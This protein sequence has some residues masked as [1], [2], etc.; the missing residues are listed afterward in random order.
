MRIRKTW[1]TLCRENFEDGDECI[2]CKQCKK[3]FHRECLQAEGL[4]DIEQL[5]DIKNYICYQCM[6]EDDD[7]PENEDRCKICRE[8]SSNLILLL[9]DG[10]PNSYHV[11]CLGLQAEPESEK[12]YCP[13]CKPEEHKNL[14]VRRMRKGFAIDNMNGDHV[15]SSSCYV[16]QRPGKLLGCDFCPNSFHPTC[17]PDLDFDNISDQWECPCCKNEDPLLNQGHKRWT[18]NEIQEI[19]KKRQKELNFW[20]SKIIKYRNRFLLAHRKDL[21][22]FVNP[23]VFANLTKTFKNDFYAAKCNTNKKGGKGDSGKGTKI[24]S[25]SSN[26]SNSGKKSL[27]L[28][29]KEFDE[30]IS[31]LEEEANK[32]ASKFIES[33]FLS[34]YQP[35]GK[36]IERRPLVDNVQLKPHQEDGV[37]WLLKSF[38]TGGA[39]LAD[40]MGLGKTI[41]TLCFLSYLKCN[42]IDGP[43]LIVVPLSTVGN[44]LR[45]IHRFTP[46][47]TCIKICGSKNERTH[48][49]EDRLAEKGL[50]DLYVTT[51]E[52]V[53]NEEEF[54]VETIPKW[55]CI[56]L[57]EAHRIKN[58]GGAIRHSMDR[59]VGNMRLL[60]TGTPLQNNSAELFTLI[61]FMFPDIFKNSEIIEQAF[62]NTPMGG[63]NQNNS[64]S[65]TNN[66]NGN[67]SGNSNNYKLNI[68]N[69]DLKSSIKEEDLKA[70]R[71]LLDKIMLRR[72]KEQAITLPRKIFHDV[73]LPLGSLS[74]HW[75]KRLLDIRSMV[76]E[77]VSVKKLL[78]LV[79][80]M[81]IICGHPKGI[82]SRPSQ[83]E[84]LFAFFEEESE[85]IKEEVKKD[86]IKLKNISGEEH[87]ESS[88]KLI[89]ID[90]LLCQL[91]YE[92]CKYVKNY[93]ANFDKHKKEVAIYH[94]HKMQEQNQSQ[95]KKREHSGKFKKNEAL[96]NSPLFMEIYNKGKL[97]LKPTSND[98]DKLKSFMHTVSIDNECPYKKKRCIYDKIKEMIKNKNNAKF[99]QNNLYSVKNP[100]KDFSEFHYKENNEN[101]N[102]TFDDEDEE[103]EEEEEE[104]TED[105]EYNYG[106]KN[107]GTKK[108][109][110]KNLK[111]VFPDEDSNDGSN[112]NGTDA[113]KEEK[114]ENEEQDEKEEK[115][116]KEE[117]N[118]Q[119]ES[120]E[121][122]SN[123]GINSKNIVTL[124]KNCKII[125]IKEFFKSEKESTN[126]EGKTNENSTQIS[127]KE[128]LEKIDADYIK[129]E[130]EG[131]TI[132]TMHLNK[133]DTEEKMMQ[134]SETKDEN[135]SKLEKNEETEENNNIVNVKKEVTIQL[136]FTRSNSNNEEGENSPK[137]EPKMHKVLIFTQFQLVLDE[138]EE[139]CKY[140]CWKYMRLDGSTN[141]L[142]RELDIREFNLSDS[143]YFI[144]LI[145]TRAGGLGINLTAAN[146]VIMYDEDWN[147]FIDLQAIDRAHRIGQKREVNVWKLMTE[148]TVEERMAFRREQKLKLDKLVVQT[149]ED[150]DMLDNFEEKLSSDEI[151]KLM[152]HGKA[153]I[154]N[155]DVEETLDLPL[156]FFIERGRRKLPIIN[157]IDLEKE[158]KNT[159]EQE[160][161][162]IKEDRDQLNSNDED[163]IY[164]Q[165][166]NYISDDEGR[167][168][169][170][171]ENGIDIDEV[172]LD[173]A[174]ELLDQGPNNNGSG[175]FYEDGNNDNNTDAVKRD[176]EPHGSNNSGIGLTSQYSSNNNGGDS[177]LWRSV[178]ERKKPQNMY[179]P[180]YWGRKQEVKQIKHEYRCFICNNT[181]NYKT[182]VKD[183]N[184]ND[185]EIDYGDMINC[186]RC[187]K[188]Y[189]KLCEGIKD[190]VVKKTWT[191]SWH[192][193]CLCF[194]KS[195]Q[196]GNLLIHCATCPT[197]F[198]YS[199]FPPD[200]IRYYVGEEYYHN[201]RQR[202]VNFN[203][204]NW[205]CFLCSK[206][207]AVEEQKKRRKMTKEERENEKQLQ[208][209]LRSQ[210][211]DSKQEEIETKKRKRAQQLERDKFIIENRKRIDALDKKY[212]M[213]L[214]SAYENLFPPKFI[215]E[216]INRI[217]QAKLL[218][219]KSGTG[220]DEENN[221]SKELSKNQNSKDSDNNTPK[222]STNKKKSTTFL[223]TKLPNKMLVLCENCK[224]PCHANY[225]YPGNCC[226]PLEL[227]K[228]YFY[229]NSSFNPSTNNKDNKNGNT[230]DGNTGCAD[231]SGFGQYPCSS[232]SSMDKKNSAKKNMTKDGDNS[233]MNQ[234]NNQVKEEEE[235]DGTE[236]KINYN[237]QNN[238]KE[239]NTTGQSN[240]NN[241]ENPTNSSR[242]NF[243]ENNNEDKNENEQ[244]DSPN[245]NNQDNNGKAKTRRFL[246]AVCSKCGT[247]QLGKLAH[248][249]KHCDKLTEEEKKEYEDKREKLKHLIELLNTKSIPDEYTE[250]EYKNMS[251]F[252]FKGLY[253]TF[254]DKADN[255]LEDCIREMK[256]D[257]LISTKKKT[258]KKEKENKK[259]NNNNNNNNG[260]NGGMGNSSG[261]S[262]GKGKGG[263][264]KD[265]MKKGGSN[266]NSS[267]KSNLAHLLYKNALINSLNKEGK[268]FIEI[269]SD[270]MTDEMKELLSRELSS[271]KGK[272]KKVINKN[273]LKTKKAKGSG[274][275]DEGNN[276]TI[277]DGIMN[278]HN[279]N[280]KFNELK[281]ISSNNNLNMYHDKLNKDKSNE[282]FTLDSFNDEFLHKAKEFLRITK[283]KIINNGFS[284]S[285]NIANVL[286]VGDKNNNMDI[287][288]SI[289]QNYIKKMKNSLKNNQP[290]PKI[291]TEQNF[292]KHHRMSSYD[293]NRS[294]S[295]SRID[296]YKNNL[297]RNNKYNI[298]PSHSNYRI[299]RGGSGDR[300]KIG[301]LV[302]EHNNNNN[303]IFTP[304]SAVPNKN[305]HYP[306]INDFNVDIFNIDKNVKHKDDSGEYDIKK[307][308][309]LSENT[310]TNKV[311]EYILYR[312]KKSN[313]NS[314][315]HHGYDE[316]NNSNF[317]AIGRMGSGHKRDDVGM[318]NKNGKINMDNQMNLKRP[319]NSANDRMKQLNL[320][321]V[322]SF[323]INA[324]RN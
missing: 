36:K 98:E 215:K 32:N 199:C 237:S 289:I 85:E 153:A 251:I 271:M 91:H 214:R 312:K 167:D 249:R 70:I 143:I 128:N 171:D 256:W 196:C 111:Q 234:N 80:K 183:R 233:N 306:D 229:A 63:N 265:G 51:Y 79:I 210:L 170:Y 59:V 75:Y 7:I 8:K 30:Y 191:C 61:N 89:F 109:K 18:K 277:E 129:K 276:N 62:M 24:T 37:E 240:Y 76:E 187:P 308:T 95:K 231:G 204:Q 175:S 176:K 1:C 127:N 285:P 202:G 11:S 135:N 238:E 200:Y 118:E 82:V 101:E 136:P 65:N 56:V 155:M 48:A 319:S 188:T 227:D 16:C 113:E 243:D 205:V 310:G 119:D 12:W 273:T 193:C 275:C 194:R 74:A 27:N 86:A 292:N 72:L 269:I 253:S 177:T 162:N 13:V 110:K 259:N 190:E 198:C 34:V 115:E 43:N 252:K 40:E 90:K 197:S 84:K 203:A 124:G 169:N 268:E 294:S 316:D 163:N 213:Q 282:H 255:I 107:K 105:D 54:F 112:E 299:N 44:W 284:E 181:K 45:E 272:R 226:Y 270:N 125:N 22:P 267:A 218:K 39:I 304:K 28:D 297:D 108:N 274:E 146:H 185:I 121:K 93:A 314:R 46:H 307:I 161:K 250:E 220:Q 142:I 217:E 17:L 322:K 138:L 225:K 172:M 88:S 71:C 287:E 6:N 157:G 242:K 207:K 92:N 324:E 305:Y 201:L 94:Y 298:Q 195:S 35:N 288:K 223:H 208:K 154:Q 20:R 323:L 247:V 116:E 293:H 114:E 283:K 81:R 266:T 21:Q 15:N 49:K 280:D 83:M 279:N 179:T 29:S 77:K 33:V 66:N 173:E 150:E 302:N 245:N 301:G 123:T 130:Y 117:K 303:R 309:S 26:S 69:I 41:Q 186:F 236:K 151:R 131:D 139:Y 122:N 52:T 241:D 5:R 165:K 137:S 25:I 144:Y 60:L 168:N 147:P 97:E 244:G 315:N 31:S 141:K 239:M 232:T 156:E 100:S 296:M 104:E 260:G 235:E 73:W 55:Q 206:C 23:K 134:V 78:G 246:R 262:S 261:N 300:I 317:N 257:M 19:M 178:R 291:M 102:K 152:L 149:Q 106:D 228:S 174:E 180:E 211:H 4:I 148:W 216:L 230:G 58:Q 14:D 219:Q 281:K 158:E 166:G 209:E 295:N 120:G 264:G 145:S 290:N 222:D 159:I 103:E 258:L 2:C 278:R 321:D 192:E 64:N 140:R 182:T 133:S 87:I 160:I 286:N 212:E 47:L 99:N 3:K 126:T 184:N 57:D 42:K 67:N 132:S 96:E 189:H 318:M 311:H 164:V 221:T 320:N 9:C 10:C 224:L 313:S 50:Y 263:G 53:K 68:G 248:F 254:Q 38:L